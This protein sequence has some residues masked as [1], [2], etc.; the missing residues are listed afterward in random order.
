[1]ETT[2]V[3]PATDEEVES[4][5][6]F[7]ALCD[8]WACYPATSPRERERLAGRAARYRDLQ[9]AALTELNI[10]ERICR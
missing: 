7:A 9:L 1:M 6:L 2:T 10:A 3:R 8:V 5:G 4:L